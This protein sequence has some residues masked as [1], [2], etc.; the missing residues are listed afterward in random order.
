MVSNNKCLP[1]Y[2]RHR[3]KV[4]I[5]TRGITAVSSQTCSDVCDTGRNTPVPTRTWTTHQQ[6]LALYTLG[7][8]SLITFSNLVHPK[9]TFAPATNNHAKPPNTNHTHHTSLGG[10]PPHRKAAAHY[11]HRR[12]DHRPNKQAANHANHTLRKMRFHPEKWPRDSPRR[13]TIRH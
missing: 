4:L 10:S 1:T 3:T 12:H 2:L 13:Q 9:L 7:P 11:A 8:Y 5:C 6:I